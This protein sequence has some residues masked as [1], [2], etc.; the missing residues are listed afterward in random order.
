MLLARRLVASFWIPIPLDVRVRAALK[1]QNW[2]VSGGHWLL[3]QRR[4][5]RG[6]YACRGLLCLFTETILSMLLCLVLRT[7]SK[8]NHPKCVE[9]EEAAARMRAKPPPRHTSRA[10]LQSSI[11]HKQGPGARVEV[12]LLQ[13]C[14]SGL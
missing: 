8:S 2:H 1:Q 10:V 5:I 14:V 13:L 9:E 4:R 12:Q 3:M 7:S 6:D 11:Q